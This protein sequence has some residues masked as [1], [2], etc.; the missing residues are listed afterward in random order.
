VTAPTVTIPLSQHL[1]A[2][3]LLRQR[4]TRKLCLHQK[5]IDFSLEDHRQKL[6]LVDLY[7]PIAS[8]VLVSD[9]KRYPPPVLLGRPSGARPDPMLM[10]RLTH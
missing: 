4:I 3:I 2:Q 6:V 8:K 7:A 9:G 1:H 10:H 5:V